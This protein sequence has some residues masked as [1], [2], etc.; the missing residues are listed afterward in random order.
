MISPDRHGKQPNQTDKKRV[1]LTDY[2]VREFG[3]QSSEFGV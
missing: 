2:H 3:A 1:R